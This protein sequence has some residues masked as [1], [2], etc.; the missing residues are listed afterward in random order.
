MLFL[1][2]RQPRIATTKIYYAFTKFP[3]ST[4]KAASQQ[5]F[6]ENKHILE[7]HGTVFFSQ[8]AFT[9]TLFH[10]TSWNWGWKF[11][12]LCIWCK[13]GTSWNGSSHTIFYLV[14][15]KQAH[16]RYCRNC[17]RSICKTSTCI[18]SENGTKFIILVPP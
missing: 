12:L 6:M 4:E 2:W 8:K 13:Y 9:C 18:G 17:I 15:L 7:G 5:N 16:K 14:K 3:H 11:L 10:F 1:L